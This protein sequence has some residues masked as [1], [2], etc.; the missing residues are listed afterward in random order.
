MR[1]FKAYELPFI[2]LKVGFHSFEYEIDK[3]FFS[4]FE[5]TQID[6]ADIK[7]DLTLERQS[8]MMILDFSIEGEVQGICDRCGAP[9]ALDVEYEDRVIVKFGDETDSSNDEILVVG[10][11][12]HILHLEHYLYEFAH[13]ALP[14][15]VVH[16]DIEDCDQDALDK[17]SEW[18]EE[19]DDEDTDPRWDALKGLK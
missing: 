5:F 14:A 16:E 11:A 13:L 3:A 19:E 6:D 2:G 17:L 15:K 18:T 1:P 12:E 8:T 4:N 10:P 9:V 7:V